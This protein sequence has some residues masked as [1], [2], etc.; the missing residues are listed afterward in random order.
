MDRPSNNDTSFAKFLED[1][2]KQNT[3]GFA[4]QLLQ[5]KY[6]KEIAEEDDDKREEQLQELIKSFERLHK[7]ITGSNVTIN[8]EKVEGELE[9]QTKI[10]QKQLEELS[11]TRKLT[12]GSVE[13]DKEMAQYRN[14]SGRDVENLVSGKTAKTGQV[15]DFETASDRLSGQGTRAREANKL[16]LS[17]TL[18]KTIGKVTKESIGGKEKTTPN[19]SDITVKPDDRTWKE[20]FGE[21]KSVLTGG[22]FTAA[23]SRYGEEYKKAGKGTQEEGMKAYDRIV[24]LEKK[25]K[26][27]KEYGFEGRPEDVKELE[28]LKDTGIPTTLSKVERKTE[29]N[30]TPNITGKNPEADNIQDSQ[31]IMADASKLDLE[32][33]KEAN[34]LLNQQLDEL[35]KI[36]E[37]LAPKTPADMPGGKTKAAITGSAGSETPVTEKPPEGPTLPDI[38]IDLPRKDKTQPK[39]KSPSKLG[40]MLK[41]GGAA[42]AIGAGAYTAYQGYSAAEDSK[43]AKLE[44]IQAKLD[45]GEID[46]KQASELRK[47]AGNT[48]T[49]EKSG[50]VGEGTGLAAGAIAGGAAGLKLGATIGTFVGGPV[51]TAVGGAIGGLAGGALGAFAG[52]KAGKYVG[53]KAGK[54]INWVSEK[55][56]NLGK[57]ISDW[58]TGKK[59]N[60]IQA[61]P[62]KQPE[63]LQNNNPVVTSSM[64]AP[65]T[66][67]AVSQTSNENR[68]L[69]RSVNNRTPSVQ[70]IISTNVN[71]SNTN[72][73]IPLKPQPRSDGG[74]ALDRYQSRIAVY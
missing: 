70:P 23:K 33:T 21:F 61:Q 60:S 24:E 13:Y 66:G 9:N 14:T 19:I 46:Q 17:P 5:L 36:G 64:S 26:S 1:I 65:I 34:S 3:R 22:D 37:A 55:A 15:I 71:N 47:E 8:L 57:G 32:L 40:R 16:N 58:W 31:E 29:T 59:D 4:T 2:Q 73:Y 35:K 30:N 69:E 68:D 52:T 48:A 28:K 18:D 72:S 25:I 54:G 38:D 11:L 63:S 20:F 56:G 74:S 42:L 6:E 45:S 51:G 50:A 62:N 44:D 53:E 10:L 67:T 43:Q 12:E 27:A 39:G 7:E 41:F 49:V